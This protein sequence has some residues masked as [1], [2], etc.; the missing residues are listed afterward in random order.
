MRDP[1][2]PFWMKFAAAGKV[3]AAGLGAVNAIKGGGGGSSG[4]GGASAT[5]SATTAQEPQRVTRIEL[6][7]EDWI[8]NLADA[9]LSQTYEATKNGR[10]IIGRA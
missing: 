10:V 3:L 8:V 4:G 9:V 7:G 2:V 6:M 5:S 1:T